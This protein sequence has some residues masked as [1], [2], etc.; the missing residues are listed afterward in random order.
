[1]TQLALQLEP[2]PLMHYGPIQSPGLGAGR[3]MSLCGLIYA[4]GGSLRDDPEPE[5]TSRLEYVTC[6][7][8]R[9][10]AEDS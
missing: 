8:C 10:K 2:V 7:E 6:P 3:R 1:M 4:V 9:A 5:G